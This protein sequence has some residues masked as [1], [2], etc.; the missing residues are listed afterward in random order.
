[1]NGPRPSP[2]ARLLKGAVRLYQL[3]L[4]PW[5]GNNCRYQPTC[6]A[7]AIEAIERHGAL[8]GGWLAARR[9]ARCHPLGGSGYD[10]VPPAPEDDRGKAAT[11]AGDGRRTGEKR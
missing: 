6:S 7:Y 3:V 10:P 2:L 5:L 1:M 9:I 8:R 4:S 11:A